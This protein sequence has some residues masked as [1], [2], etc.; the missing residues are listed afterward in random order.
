MVDDD[1]YQHKLLS[2]VLRDANLELVFATSSTEAMAMLSRR[3]PDLILMDVD[4][5]DIDG[6]ET[7]RRIRS[8]ERLAGIPV[9]MLTGHSDKD[10]VVRSMTVGATGF[11]VKPLNKDALL[12]KIRSCLN[13]A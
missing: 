13:G 2:A 4:M 12:A 6:I 8:V 10:V 5:P 3:R 1:K 11:L 7:T 9:V